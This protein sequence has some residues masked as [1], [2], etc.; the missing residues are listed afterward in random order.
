MNKCSARASKRQQQSVR[1][2][3]HQA[4]ATVF[5]NALTD[6]GMFEKIESLLPEHRERLYTPTD[7]L[8]MFMAQALNADR[9][10][11]HAVD[12]WF[13]SRQVAGLVAVS[14]NT[15]A[16]CRARQRL[17]TYMVRELTR[18]SGRELEKSLPV[19]W[20]WKG[21]NIK[22]VDGTTLSMPDT[23]DNQSVYPQPKTQQSGVGFPLCRLV[24]MLDLSGGGVIDLAFGAC[25]GKGSAE[26]GLLRTQLHNLKKVDVLL[27]DAFFPSYFLLWKLQ[28][29]GVDCLCEQMGGRARSTDFRKG[30]SLGARDHLIVY[31]KPV[32]KPDWLSQSD[33]DAAPSTLQVRELRISPRKGV[34]GKILIT[35]LCNANKYRKTDLKSPYKDRWQVELNFRHIKTTLGMDVLS[36]HSPEMVEKEIWVYLLAYNLIGTLMAQSALYAGCKPNEISFKHS[37]QLWLA[38]D[39]H[40]RVNN[41]EDW[42][43]LMI[44]MAQKRVNN[45]PGRI[46]P[47][48]K[49]RRP[50][51]FSWLMK[52]GHDARRDVIK[53]GHD[54]KLAA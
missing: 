39:R 5:F 22:M 45:R 3:Q 52:P 37:I 14:T 31:S 18:Y 16:Y 20:K 10:C 30:E 51:P 42:A 35:T 44:A 17:P 13:M 48:Q 1:K 7:T 49:K 2:I 50:K 19:K 32:I 11:Q 33:Y 15:G 23:P 38:W 26:P 36:C 47:R 43:A 24:G 21:R 46:E 29:M 25:E 27:A 53:Y 41:D 54:V 28:T 4:D 6:V 40:A 9:S 8:S 34:K 12:E